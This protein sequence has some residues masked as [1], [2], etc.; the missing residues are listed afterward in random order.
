M[1]SCLTGPRAGQQG[2]SRD[3]EARQQ[4]DL[5]ARIGIYT[6]NICLLIPGSS[7]DAAWKLHS[8]NIGNLFIAMDTSPC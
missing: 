8:G 3:E 7:V 2:E 1:T 5:G 4:E 6:I